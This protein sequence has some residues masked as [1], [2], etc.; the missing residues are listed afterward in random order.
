MAT[1]KTKPISA[2]RKLELSQLSPVA[3]QREAMGTD[4]DF[5]KFVVY[6]NSLVKA[7]L[8]GRI[9][10]ASINRTIEGAGTLTVV[11]N[12]YDRVV[13]KSGILTEKMDVQID[14]LWFRLT[15]V[16]KQ[17]DE[18]VLTFED[19]EV[20]ILRTYV[21]WRIAQRDK[22]TRAEFVLSLIREVKEFNIPV[23]IP[24]LHKVQAIEKYSG[25]IFGAEAA[26]N[27]NKGIPK[28]INSSAKSAYNHRDPVSKSGAQILTVKGS[29]ATDDQIANANTIL[30]VADGL[31]A[32]RVVKVI[33]I[34]TAIQE[35]SLVNLPGGPAAHNKTNDQAGDDSAGLYQQRPGWG[36][37]LDRTDPPTAARLFLNGSGTSPGLIEV[38]QD[39]R[40]EQY[41]VIAAN[42]QHPAQKYEV[43]YAKH[44]V[45]AERFVSA[46]GDPP[47]DTNTANNQSANVAYTNNPKGSFYFF[48]GNIEDKAGNPVRKK[49][50]TWSC[51]QRLADEVDLR[52]FFVSGTFYWISE[53][54]LLKQLP[55]ATVREFQNGVDAINGQYDRAKK[56]ATI[57]L[58]VE[59]GRWAVPPGSVVVVADAGPYSGRWIVNEYGRDL[60]GSNRMATITLKKPRPQL[61]EPLTSNANNILTGWI[62]QVP[63][64]SQVPPTDGLINQI[65]Q[66]NRIT[67]SNKLETTDITVGAIDDRVLQFMQWLADQGYSYIVTAL[68]S[69]HNALTT[70]GRPSAHAS[71]RAVD[72]GT[73]N[74]SNAD[75]PKVMK[76]ISLNQ[77]ILGFD[78]LIGPYPL[79]CLPLGIYDAQTLSEH[80]S[81][82]H[83]GFSGKTY[84]S[85]KDK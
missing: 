10:E 82:I 63:A 12:D 31:G 64:T 4:V 66:N 36:S 13:L 83:V 47:T 7:D 24:E 55:L 11:I 6:I 20:A 84:T 65:L 2:R 78:Q 81:H 1:S 71:G 29:E 46:F 45:E 75:T 51:L 16:D 61:P 30:Q 68:K 48:R 49:E 74:S 33:S 73:F 54:D 26:T 15:T 39:L 8:S 69:D 14:G 21:K 27:K 56:S 38:E 52:A 62:P 50:D 76:L 23:V 79:L 32:N 43:L 9:I 3:V 59:V 85:P 80:K 70:E 37:Y 5:Q 22:V 18:L 17:E 58:E 34:M 25:D 60:I 77:P 35:S 19:R 41:W 44:R 67:F 42:V 28:D 57:T 72:I 40:G 53:K